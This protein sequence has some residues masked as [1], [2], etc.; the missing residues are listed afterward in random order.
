MVE[1]LQREK[2]EREK[3]EKDFK[4]NVKM[5]SQRITIVWLRITTNFQKKVMI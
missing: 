5:I 2:Q 1:D 3:L 4:K